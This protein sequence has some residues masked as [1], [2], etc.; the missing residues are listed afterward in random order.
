MQYLMKSSSPV[1]ICLQYGNIGEFGTVCA[2]IQNIQCS[3]GKRRVCSSASTLKE[4]ITVWITTGKTTLY[5]Q[6]KWETNLGARMNILT[7]FSHIYFRTRKQHT[8]FIPKLKCVSVYV[9]VCVCFT[10]TKHMPNHRHSLLNLDNIFLN[11]FDIRD[12]WA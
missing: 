8:P 5:H 10:L 4:C 6:M 9:Y 12:K 7:L 1:P 11:I 2:E 3:H